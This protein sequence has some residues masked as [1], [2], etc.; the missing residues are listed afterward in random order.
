MISQVPTL[1]REAYLQV[2]LFDQP[3]MSGNKF[4]ST[5]A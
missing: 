2:C 1:K 5:V 3:E 4:V